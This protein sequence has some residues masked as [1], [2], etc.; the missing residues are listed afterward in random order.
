MRFGKNKHFNKTIKQ[1][2]KELKVKQPFIKTINKI[3]FIMVFLLAGYIIAAPFLPAVYLNI[4]Q[5]ADSTKGFKYDS[6]LAQ[7]AV[8][9]QSIKTQD[10]K[11]IPNENTLVI[12]QI[13]VDGKIYDGPDQFTLNKG[14]WRRPNTNTPDKGG[15]TVLTAHRFLYTSGANTFYSLDKLK[16]GD[17]LAVFWNQKE[18]D[19]EIFDITIVKPT[20]IDVENQTTNSIL[21]LYTC[22][23]LWTSE[24]RL[25]VKAKLLEKL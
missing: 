12:P 6:L 13:G 3:L 2:N 8:V 14:I 23:P 17:K 11:A 7:K 15:N 5:A 16:K 25:V 9:S 4:T 20:Q 24:D 10:L 21:T 18:Y 1:L 22:T 19:Y